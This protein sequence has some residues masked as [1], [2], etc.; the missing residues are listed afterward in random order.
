MS[1][2]EDILVEELRR[3]LK[4]DDWPTFNK[5]EEFVIEHQVLRHKVASL[6]VTKYMK[7]R[8]VPAW[9]LFGGAL[10]HP[11]SPLYTYSFRAFPKRLPLQVCHG[12]WLEQGDVVQPNK[13]SEDANNEKEKQQLKKQWAKFEKPFDSMV[14]FSEEGQKFNVLAPSNL[15]FSIWLSHSNIFDGVLQ[16]NVI[17]MNNQPT[18]ELWFWIDT[19]F[20]EF[21]LRT[22]VGT[23]DLIA[24]LAGVKKKIP[25][26]EHILLVVSNRT[27]SSS[28]IEEL[29][30]SILLVSRT[31]DRLQWL[32]S[33]GC[34]RLYVYE[35]EPTEASN[36]NNE[37]NKKE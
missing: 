9:M 31:D 32:L 6:F 37:T 5:F 8:I 33:P 11:N 19:K 12:D 1:T 22:A 30:Q 28:L 29:D 27:F 3:V 23:K 2:E 21:G 14:K 20:S 36:A 34:A 17:H 10:C 15:P 24:K 35:N 16:E 18:R 26:R 7:S 25:E 4:V 13:R